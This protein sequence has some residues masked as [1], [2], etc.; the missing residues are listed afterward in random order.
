[1]GTSSGKVENNKYLQQL[2]HSDN[3]ST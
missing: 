1:M 2:D 3:G